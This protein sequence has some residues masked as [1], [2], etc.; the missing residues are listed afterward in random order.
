MKIS[1]FWERRDAE[2]KRFVYVVAGYKFVFI[3]D[4][5]YLDGEKLILNELDFFEADVTAVKVCQ[6][7][8]GARA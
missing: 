1:V 3:A 8:E 2:K 7:L 6:K 5:V 4:H